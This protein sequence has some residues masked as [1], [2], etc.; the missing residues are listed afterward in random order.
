MWRGGFLQVDCLARRGDVACDAVLDGQCEGAP[1]LLVGETTSE[2]LLLVVHKEHSA[3]FALHRF[4][5][6][7]P[8]LEDERLDLELLRCKELLEPKLANGWVGVVI[9]NARLID[10]LCLCTPVPCPTCY[11]VAW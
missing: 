6:G 10:A 11:K 5:C 1:S 4:L 2:N 8:D 7:F 9:P 3:L